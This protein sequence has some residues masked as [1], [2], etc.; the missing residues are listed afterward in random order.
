MPYARPFK[1]VVC[2]CCGRKMARGSGLR[3]CSSLSTA[4]AAAG[5]YEAGCVQEPYG[6]WTRGVACP[7]R[8]RRKS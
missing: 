1:L 7:R 4:D 8:A 6:D 5:C 2:L 3:M